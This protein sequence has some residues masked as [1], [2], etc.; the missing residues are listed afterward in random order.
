MA[1]TEKAVGRAV[2][3]KEDPE[4][5]T[6]E[7]KYA[8]D[9]ALPGMLHM[10][11]VRSPFAHAKI[12]SVDLSK[13]LAMDRVVAA[14]GGQDLTGDWAGPLLMAWPV[15]DD[16]HNPPHWPLTTDKARY[17]GDGVAVVVAESR[18]AAK[19]AAEAVEV[20][21]EP[22]DAVVDMEAA[23]ADGATLVHDEFG[24]NASYTWTLVNG[25]P[26]KEFDP[27]PVLGKQRYVLQ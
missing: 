8:D 20:D 15:T 22:L 3:R 4:L 11:V 2:L 26:D 12:N 9:L 7:A 14:F 19:D 5:L 16:I 18:A 21:Y 27:A 23:L 1:V 10:I 6:G 13:A 24:T 17:Q 25:E